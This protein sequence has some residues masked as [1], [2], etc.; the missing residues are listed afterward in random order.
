MKTKTLYFLV[1]S[2]IFLNC[3]DKKSETKRK[4]NSL[5]KES[6]PF[7]KTKKKE[8]KTKKNTSVFIELIIDGKKIGFDKIDLKNNGTVVLFKNNFQLKYNDVN[9]ETVL[10]HLYDSD[11]YDKTPIVFKT[12]VASLPRKEQAMVK[13]KASK[14]SFTI[15]N[16]DPD[17]N[18][19]KELYEGEVTLKEF[20][21]NQIIILFDGFGYPGGGKPEKK[22]LFP[23]KGKIVIKNYNTYDAR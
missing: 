14:L 5:I 8:D 10:I 3:S 20:T 16:E 23:M 12:Q 18:G 9:N 4:E 1:F 15:M 7:L 19:F 6:K 21:E 11:I 22:K 17:F 2:F 13:T